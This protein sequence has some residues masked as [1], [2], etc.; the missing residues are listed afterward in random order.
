M[1]HGPSREESLIGTLALALLI[2]GCADVLPLPPRPVEPAQN[3]I[4]DLE[5]AGRVFEPQPVPPGVVPANQVVEQL[6]ADGF[7]PFAPSGA[8]PAPPTYGV[9]TCVVRARCATGGFAQEGPV[10]IWLVVWPEVSGG[11]GGLA[12]A[13][14]D[15]A[16]GAFIFGDGPP[17]G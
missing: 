15:A 13:A 5:D 1:Q 8:Q 6:Q 4:A 3:F 16:T 10:G 12:W 7:P 9:V 2:V 11:N 14:V 17:G